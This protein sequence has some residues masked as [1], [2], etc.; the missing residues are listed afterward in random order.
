MKIKIVNILLIIVSIIGS[1]YFIITRDRQLDLILKDASIV[2][3]ITLPYIIEKI[4]K[5]RINEEVKSI[6]ILFI[7]MAHFLG[8]IVELYNMIYC[9]DKI[10]HFLSGIVSALVAFIILIKTDKYEE[11]SILFNII[12][13]L[14]ITML[15][16]S[17]WEVFE[18]V[19]NIFFGGDAQ[20]VALTGVNDTM[21][22][23]IVA[24]L[25]AIL[26]CIMYWYEVF[27]N[28]KI[29][30]KRFIDNII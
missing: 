18:Y 8:V 10:T 23:M 11:K 6:Y 15:I 28:T 14:A 4:F 13:I 16:A 25:G 12:Y 26:T 5:I 1:S 30:V 21:Q 22:D 29:I 17:C 27:A 19:A 20:R 3:T 2:F 7:F 9:Y 24:L